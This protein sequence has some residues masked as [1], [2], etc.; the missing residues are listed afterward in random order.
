MLLEKRD[1]DKPRSRELARSQDPPQVDARI[2]LATPIN[3]QEART[4]HD[5]HLENECWL[6]TVGRRHCS[7]WAPSLFARD[8]LGSTSL[9]CFS[10]L[11]YLL[12]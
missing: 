4:G 12:C 1:S 5:L 9:E 6:L 7:D 11:E 2:T 10:D 3:T 8:H